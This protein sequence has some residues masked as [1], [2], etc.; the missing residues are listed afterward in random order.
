MSEMPQKKGKLA[1]DEDGDT[2]LVNE[3]GDIFEADSIV[4]AIW[5]SFDGDLS[6][7]K[8]ASDIGEESGEDEEAI[9]EGIED[10]LDKLEEADLV[11]L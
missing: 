7:D 11:K 10:I 6:V 5:N 2:V 9:K 3:N 8:M 1:Q 4:I